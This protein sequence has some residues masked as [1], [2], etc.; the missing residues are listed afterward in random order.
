LSECFCIKNKSYAKIGFFYGD[1]ILQ[2]IFMSPVL[3]QKIAKKERPLYDYS[4][5]SLNQNNST[6]KKNL[7]SHTIQIPCQ[8][9]NKSIIFLENMPKPTK[10]NIILILIRKLK[11]IKISTI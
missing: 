6:M 7:T 4:G 11:K 3:K 8:N 9:I 1:T 5:P 2:M 10:I